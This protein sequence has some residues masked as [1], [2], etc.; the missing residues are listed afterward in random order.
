MRRHLEWLALR[1]LR[2]STIEARRNALLRLERAAGKRLVEITERDLTSWQAGLRLS[3]K[4]HQA[5]VSHLRQFFRWAVDRGFVPSDPTRKLVTPRVHKPLPRPISEERLS[6]A[7]DNAPDR[8]RPWLILASHAGLRACEIAGLQRRDILDEADPPLIVLGD[9]AKGGRHGCVPMNETV[10]EALLRHGL[11][12]S[13]Y[14]FRRADGRPGPN[15]PWRISQLA[16]AYLHDMGIPD[17][18]HSL[19]HR[20]CTS[21]YRE[22]QD[23]M[24][25]KALARHENLATTSGYVQFSEAKAVL[26]VRALDRPAASGQASPA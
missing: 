17:T 21:W 26:T 1:G 12:G 24:V 22:S 8:V 3:P 20:A 10:R 5:E 4:A 16:N 19:R 6:L 2:P 9:T 14:V 13:G 23:L 11:P 18:F 7:I 25:V 15:R